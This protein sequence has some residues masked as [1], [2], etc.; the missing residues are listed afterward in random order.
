MVISSRAVSGAPSSLTASAALLPCDRPRIGGTAERLGG[1]AI[2]E[3]VLVLDGL[4][5]DRD[6]EIAGLQPRLRRRAFRHHARDERAGRPLQPHALG[7]LGGDVLQFCAEPGPLHRLAAALRRVEH[8]THHVDGNGEAD[9]DRAAR[10][11]EDRGIDADEAA[12]HVDE[13]AAGIAEVDRGVGLDEERIVGNADLRAR[14]RRD[15]SL[16][17]RL[18]DAERI[19]DR[20]HEVADLNLRRNRRTRSPE[21]ARGRP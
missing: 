5:I 10:A 2:A 1:E 20:E 15:D 3:S 6:D 14:E 7:D 17:H 13:R 16:R 4:A 12:R 9:A 11:R 8:D 19:A 18:P 21:S